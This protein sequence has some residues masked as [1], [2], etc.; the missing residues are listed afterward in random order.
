[1]LDRLPYLEVQVHLFLFLHAEGFEWGG[2]IALRG[3]VVGFLGSRLYILILFLG[4]PNFIG[5]MVR[6][7]CLFGVASGFVLEPE[8]K[9]VFFIFL[10]MYDIIMLG[11]K[12]LE[13]LLLFPLTLLFLLLYDTMADVYKMQH[14][15]HLVG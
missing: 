10:A 6:V 15:S 3:V 4:R 1:M 9:A 13:K 5:V 7:D 14:S 11:P 12:L 2:K 8:V